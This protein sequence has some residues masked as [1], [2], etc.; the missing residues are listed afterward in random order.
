MS[1]TGLSQLTGFFDQDIVIA[2]ERKAGRGTSSVSHVE[3][4]ISTA[5]GRWERMLKGAGG[6]NRRRVVREIAVKVT[7]GHRARSISLAVVVRVAWVEH[8]ISVGSLDIQRVE[9]VVQRALLLVEISAAG[10]RRVR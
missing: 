10:G 5:R 8:S 4:V 3:V 7:G 1:L 6:L 2:V 9:V